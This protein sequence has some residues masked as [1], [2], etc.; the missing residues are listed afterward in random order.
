MPV[1]V[2]PKLEYQLSYGVECLSS[3]EACQLWTETLLHSSTVSYIGKKKTKV[4][5]LP[6]ILYFL[7]SVKIKTLSS[8]VMWSVPFS[9]CF[10]IVAKKIVKV[11]A[12]KKKR[13]FSLL[14][15]SEGLVESTWQIFPQTNGIVF[16]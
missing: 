3:S 5:L 8:S 7:N 1:H 11:N 9:L 15:P 6:A 14:P 13:E 12:A 4:L 10:N 2:L 16:R